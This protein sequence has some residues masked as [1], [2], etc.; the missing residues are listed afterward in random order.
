[1]SRRRP[2]NHIVPA[3]GGCTPIKAGHPEPPHQATAS[4]THGAP[5]SSQQPGNGAIM[6]A[7]HTAVS[8]LMATIAVPGLEQPLRF[9]QITDSH[10]D[11]GLDDGPLSP[12]DFQQLERTITGG[13]AVGEAAAAQVHIP[14]PPP[15]VPPPPSP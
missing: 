5:L 12:E 13:G 8:D 6:A 7:Q 4:H 9:I 1:M 3:H 11:L 10:V 2:A 14:A 15:P